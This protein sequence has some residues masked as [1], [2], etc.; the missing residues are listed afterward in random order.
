MLLRS[1]E[2]GGIDKNYKTAG[3]W[4]WANAIYLLGRGTDCSQS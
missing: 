4:L 3:L 2:D 1:K